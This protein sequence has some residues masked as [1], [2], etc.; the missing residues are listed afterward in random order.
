MLQNHCNLL[1]I[2]STDARRSTQR[3]TGTDRRG[4]GQCNDSR[5][6]NCGRSSRADLD[7]HH[8]V[9]Q[10]ARFD[11]E[12]FSLLCF[13]HPG[14]RLFYSVPF[15]QRSP[16]TNPNAS[17]GSRDDLSDDL[18]N[19]YTICL[20]IW[21]Y[22]ANATDDLFVVSCPVRLV[23]E[24]GRAAARQYD[25]GDDL[26]FAGVGPS[27]S[28]RIASALGMFGW[29]GARRS[30]LFSGSVLSH[31]R[32]CGPLLSFG[33]AFGRYRCGSLSLLGHHALCTASLN[34]V[35]P[36]KVAGLLFRTIVLPGRIWQI[37]D[38][39]KNESLP[40]ARRV[41]GA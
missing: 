6:R 36:T 15:V 2:E 38:S 11:R 3:S 24:S 28:A 4:M 19:L 14:L 25:G 9:R 26:P 31:V 12:L 41:D 37:R 35:H 32:S 27:I 34:W 17:L 1:K 21:R 39:E 16:H 13:S 23:A 5:T 22:H 33:L 10:A 30:D 20:A 8:A 29:H 7:D 18:G 40:V